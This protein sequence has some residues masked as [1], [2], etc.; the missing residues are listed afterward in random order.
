[1]PYGIIYVIENRENGRYYIGQT[2]QDG[3]DRFKQHL[4][5]AKR[6]NCP[7]QNAIRKYGN[8][9]FSIRSLVEANSP[10]EL[11]GLE[12]LWIISTASNV[13]WVGYNCDTGGKHQSPNGQTRRKMSAAASRRKYTAEEIEKRSASL[14]GQKRTGQALENLRAGFR[15]TNFS[16]EHR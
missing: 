2:T 14:R 7:L 11:N 1:M 13:K 16:P 3:K 8:D 5:D 10:Q 15:K 9:A 6:K 12:T 4:A